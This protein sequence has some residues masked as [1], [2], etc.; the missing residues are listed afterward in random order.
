MQADLADLV[1]YPRETL[2]IELKA[3]LDLKQPLVRAKIARHMAALSNHGGG[4]LVFGFLDDLTRDPNAPPNILH[5]DRDE[6]TGIA[7]H[8]LTPSFQCDVSRVAA[9]DGA[10]YVVVRVPGHGSIP[11]AA[12]A[13]GPSDAKGR[14]Q[15]IASG[16][17]YLRKAG[18][19]SAPIVGAEDWNAIIRRC[20]LSDRQSL[21]SDIASLVQAPV[22][23]AKVT[24]DTLIEWD[25]ESEERWLQLL[26]HAHELSWSVSIKN[27][28][29]RLSYVI[30]TEAEALPQADLRRLLEEVNID[31]RATVWTGWSMFYPF[32]RPEIAPAFHAEKSDGTGGDV[33][34]ANLMG[35]G[36]LDT[37]LPDFWRIAPDGRATIIRPYREDRL[38]SVTSLN[39]AAGTWLSPETIIRETAEIVTHATLLARR[40]ETATSVS[41]RCTWLGLADRQIDE[42]DPSIYWSPGKVAKADN[43]TIEGEWALADLVNS[44]PEIVSELACPVLRI[45]G[46]E[47]CG[48]TLVER[49]AP[50]F[51]KL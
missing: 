10:E 35:M 38:R 28:R 49:M 5:Y 31:V 23:A 44:W 37:S 29:C 40:F 20:V 30:G 1:E 25:R 26:A 8:Y 47:E 22:P 27:N 7:K 11:I 41:F 45:F 43:R 32:T 13:N 9:S 21:L 33:L 19:E 46:F 6:F 4:Y 16:T 15:G 48:P 24:R 42:F 12:K 14:A 36:D 50:R 17:Y 3:W 34:E 39:R 51:V 18:P 2:E